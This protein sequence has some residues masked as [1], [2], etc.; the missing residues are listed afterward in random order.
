MATQLGQ[1]NSWNKS[2]RILVV[3]R[4]GTM[5]CALVGRNLVYSAKNMV[6]VNGCVKHVVRLIFE[7][8]QWKFWKQMR[9]RQ[10]KWMYKQWVFLMS[11]QCSTNIKVLNTS[12]CSINILFLFLLFSLVWAFLCS[13]QLN[14]R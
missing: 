7:V 8:P 1:R 13:N 5:R 12:Q 2:I 9:R 11:V 10:H 4:G 6:L 3:D 14:L